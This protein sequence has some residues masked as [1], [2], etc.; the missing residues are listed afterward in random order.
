MGTLSY[1]VGRYGATRGSGAATV[2]GSEALYSDDHTTTTSASFVEDDGTDITLP[3]GVIFR[4]YA[5]EAMRI[6]FGGTAATTDTGHYIAATTTFECEVT[7]PGKV[8]IIDV[9]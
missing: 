2:M 3:A 8:S 7:E 4:G 6:R 9:A 1:S 5:S